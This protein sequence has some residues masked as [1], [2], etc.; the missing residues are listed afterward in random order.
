MKNTILIV[1]DEKN[2]REGLQKALCGEYEITLAENADKALDI[3]QENSFDVILT[4]LKMPGLDGMSFTKQVSADSPE[5]I[6][7]LMTA[8]G[9]IEV[10]VNA[11]KAG[12]YD[13]LTKPVNLDNLEMV[14][15]RGLDSRKL[16]KENELLKDELGKKFG[17]ENFIGQSRELKN[18]FEIIHQVADA[19]T[20][21]LITGESGTGKELAAHALHSLSKRSEQPM[22]ILHCASL[23]A[24][25]LESEI[26]GHEKG[27]F[28]GATAR[29]IGRI[30][31]AAGGTIFLD[32]IGEIDLSTQ[33]KL[34]RVLENKTFER[35]GGN[36]T[37]K[38]DVRIIA[39]T[40][41]DLKQEVR[42][43]QFRQ[44]FYYRLSVLNIHMPPLRN[45]AEDI[46]ILLNNFLDVFNKENNKRIKRFSTEAVN[47]L[48]AY[49]WPGNVRELRN[50]VERMVVMTRGEIL[51]IAD[52]PS[53]ITQTILS[54][55]K[56]P[57]KERESFD[58]D[59][60]EKNLISKALENSNNNI[61]K[62]ADKLGISR[63]T[64]HRKIKK[65][66]L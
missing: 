30:E 29:K 5:T 66:K 54:T 22:I 28:T 24:N 23:N 37:L 55:E 7:V 2:T 48:I 31:N 8:Y 6:I 3:L 39:A 51:T 36:E 9:S 1:D 58:I 26:F 50:I 27:A 44:D 56:L 43:K 47:L 19:K 61:T 64:L 52:I 20:T 63:R 35:V 53:E 18:V 33:I 38:A 14:I 21:V 59:N 41:R 57:S 34:L 62:T 16:S 4:D 40:N 17:I 10:A 65:Y 45:H 15:D 13:Y 11:M 42:K 12:A 49:K 46:P 60:N 32:E 25:L